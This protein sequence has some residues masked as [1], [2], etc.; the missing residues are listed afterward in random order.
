MEYDEQMK[1]LVI[2]LLFIATALQAAV[3]RTVDKHGNVVY[4]DI[5]DERSEEVIIDI[6]P[7]YTPLPIPKVETVDADE[8]EDNVEEVPNYQIKIISPA[9]DESFQNPEEI[10]VVAAVSPA[11]NSKR[12]DKLQFKLD[13]KPVQSPQQ[14]TSISLSALERGSHILVV[15]VVD[16]SGK[17]LKRSKSILFHVHRRSVGH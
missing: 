8:G 4:T 13:G 10:T 17:A 3:Y 15:S 16:K 6:A 9:Q 11:L 2:I 5:E 12:A 14:G 1:Y 7:S